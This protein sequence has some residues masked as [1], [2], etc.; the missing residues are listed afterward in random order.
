MHRV[1]CIEARSFR[2]VRTRQKTKETKT[3]G[4]QAFEFQLLSPPVYPCIL[5]S[6]SHCWLRVCVCGSYCGLFPC[7]LTSTFTHDETLPPASS[8]TALYVGEAI[9]LYGWKNNFLFLLLFLSAFKR[10]NTNNS[11]YATSSGISID[12]KPI[13]LEVVAFAP[14]YIALSILPPFS[15]LNIYIPARTFWTNPKRKCRKVRWEKKQQNK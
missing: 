1:V 14:G 2:D 9:H 13:V 12:Y 11:V 6:P 5:F 8:N 3:S 4:C 15:A 7:L 10:E